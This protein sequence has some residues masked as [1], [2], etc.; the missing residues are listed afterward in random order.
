MKSKKLLSV[1]IAIFMFLFTCTAPLISF[2]AVFANDGDIEMCPGNTRAYIEKDKYNY[3]WLDSVILRDGSLAVTPL[4]VYPVSDYPYSLTYDEYITECNNY[5]ELYKASD[6]AVQKTVI[7]TLK[8]V[9]YTLVSTGKI[10]D[11]NQNMRAYNESYGI[12]YPF[13]ESQFTDIYTLITYVCLNNNVYNVISGEDIDITRGTTIEGAVV[14]YLSA[15]CDM[16]LP[17]DVDSI[18]AFS[19]LFTEKYVIEDSEYPVSED[20]SEEEV[21][22][23]V[24]LQAAQKAGYD[25]PASTRYEDLSSAQIE[26]VTYAYYASLLKTKYDVPIDPM[27]LKAA[28]LSSDPS[29]KTPRLVL[30][31][32]LEYVSV[33]YSDSESTAVLFEKAAKEGFFELENEFYTDIFNYN[34]FVPADCDKVWISCFPIADQ[35]DD[36]NN[37]KVSIY[38]NGDLVKNNSTVPV[39]ISNEGTTFVVRTS[40]EGKDDKASYSFTVTKTD[41]ATNMNEAPSIDLS[42]PLDGLSSSISN[43][44]SN[45][46]SGSS[47]YSATPA[48]GYTFNSVPLTTYSIDESS[49]ESSPPVYSVLDTYPTDES[50]EVLTTRDPL[51]IS[52]ENETE[53]S[54]LNGVANTVRDNPVVV[55]APAGLLAI[56]ASAGFMF[57]RRRK[58]DDMNES[59][60][61]E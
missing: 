13:T 17:S 48:Q 6:S 56:G 61:T 32:M 33:S 31:S 43:Y 44:I 10:T 11:S 52:T 16:D 20:A 3:A 50:G 4:T 42:E 41:D 22:Y 55:A 2:A 40:Y 9:Y 21:Y 28:L 26:Y 49:E 34:V 53:V 37:E 29:E 38:V 8:T 47:V 19:Y 7:D 30:E 15:V 35:L 57:Y 12:V 23:W 18:P 24:K 5:M 59:D 54:V 27:R 39:K 36:G 25:V 46:A 60:I 1:F 51:E 58:D 14:K 45:A